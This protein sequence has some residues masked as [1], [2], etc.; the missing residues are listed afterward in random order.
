MDA[1]Y[2]QTGQLMFA[3]ENNIVRFN[4]FGG[5]T[6]KININTLLGARCKWQ[7]SISSALVKRIVKTVEHLI[8]SRAAPAPVHCGLQ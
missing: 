3:I 5:N 2:L 4:Y 6:A 7:L 1:V 8:H